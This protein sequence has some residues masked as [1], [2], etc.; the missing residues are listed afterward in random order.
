V[1]YEIVQGLCLFNR[2]VCKDFRKVRGVLFVD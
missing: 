2:K 1:F